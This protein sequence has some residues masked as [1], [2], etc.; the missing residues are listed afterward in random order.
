MS[1]TA[2]D[3]VIRNQLPDDALLVFLSDTHIG[4]AAD[5]DIFESAALVGNHD[6]EARWNTR[7]QRLLNEA[8]LVDVFGL[9]YAASFDS[10]PEQLIYCA[11]GMG[12]IGS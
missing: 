7:I 4:G 9:S 2:A 5:S 1:D 6:A 10:L 3:A 12:S 11:H 8:G